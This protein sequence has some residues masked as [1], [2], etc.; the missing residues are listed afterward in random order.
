MLRILTFTSLYPNPE[1]PRHG[2]F[3]ETRLR[4][5]LTSRRVEAK[6][7]APVPWFPLGS[8]RF[9]RYGAFSRVPH[10]EL[11]HGIDVRHPRFLT[12]P[13]VGSAVSPVAM[14]A[15]AL[16][17]LRALAREGFDFDAIDAHFFFPDGVAAMLLGKWLAKPVVITARGSDITYWPQSALPLRMIRWAARAAGCCAAVSRA[18]ADEMVRLGL[19]RQPPRVLRNGVDL[20][21]F[22]PGGRAEARAE[23]GFEGRVVLSVGNLIELKGH[24]LAIE[25][26]A[27]VPGASLVIIGSGP[28]EARLRA[29]AA[30]LGLAARV[31]FVRVVPQAD[32]RR[33][34][35][36]ADLLVLASSRE[37]WPNVLLE[38]MACGTP[39]LATRVWGMPEVVAAPEAGVLVP[40]RTVAALQAGLEAL[41][42][43]PPDRAATRRY[44]EGFDWS[45]TTAAQIEMFERL[46]C[47]RPPEGA[48]FRA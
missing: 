1:Q 38:A 48:S 2:V 43:A 14:A 47:P 17:V 13:A 27:T 33:Y 32:L 39:V 3:I 23:L 24:H 31:R 42:S 20:A 11:R 18:L 4:H 25:A 15:G 40:E 35:V 6:V 29:L 26:L 16:P 5:L 12:V 44:A 21:L 28:E 10:R 41:L 7:V 36:A 8:P 9:G 19:G 34:Y 22:H 46:S 37:G 45:A 30:R